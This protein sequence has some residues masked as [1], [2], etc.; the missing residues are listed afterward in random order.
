VLGENMSF[1]LPLLAVSWK[2]VAQII[3]LAVLGIAAGVVSYSL[4]QAHPAFT[5]AMS[6]AA[7][8]IPVAAYALVLQLVFQLISTIRELF[9]R[10]EK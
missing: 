3:G 8:A 9:G 1:A 5:Q 6:I 10:G 4:I 7:Y 2:T